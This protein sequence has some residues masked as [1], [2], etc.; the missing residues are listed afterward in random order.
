MSKSVSAREYSLN[1]IESHSVWNDGKGDY[2]RWDGETGLLRV[3]NYHGEFYPLIT[4]PGLDAK[5]FLENFENTMY[6]ASETDI[7]WRTSNYV[8]DVLS[9]MG[10]GV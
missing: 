4:H 9:A 8:L 1:E 7:L 3:V 5:L 6:P 2:W 10:R